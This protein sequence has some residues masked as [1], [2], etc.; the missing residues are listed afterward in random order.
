MPTKL[1]SKAEGVIHLGI[2]RHILD[3]NIEVHVIEVW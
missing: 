2:S 3:Y 1:V